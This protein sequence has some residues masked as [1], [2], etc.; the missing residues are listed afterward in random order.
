MAKGHQ[1]FDVF[2]SYRHTESDK[3]VVREL[4]KF[5]RHYGLTIWLDEDMIQPGVS[6]QTMMEV[7]IKN[8]MSGA[9]LLGREPIGPWQDEEVQALL[10]Y[11][12]RLKLPMIPVLLPSASQVPAL[13]VFLSNRRWVDFRA[14]FTADG[15]SQ[16]IWGITGKKIMLPSAVSISTA[17]SNIVVAPSKTAPANMTEYISKRGHLIHKLK[18][19][20]STGRWAYYFILVEEDLEKAFL[21]ALESDESI[22]L[23]DYGR[24]VA[25]CYGE[26]ADE[27][28]RRMLKEKYGF[29]V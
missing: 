19:K 16:L 29:D 28:T 11:A 17:S 6:W 8:S 22:D 7:G 25:S 10:Q 9:I 18:A 21:E 15:I 14:G 12:V 2:F 20:D 27:N 13:P 4:A 5:L 23:E 3:P 26:G 24:V 1:A